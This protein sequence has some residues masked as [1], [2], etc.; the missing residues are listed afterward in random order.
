MANL[1]IIQSKIYEIRGQKVML[2]FDL[3]EL[4]SIETRVLKQAVRRNSARF[5]GEDFMFELTKEEISRSQIVILNK[6]RGSNIKYAPFAFTELGV[7]MLSS[8]LNS[9]TAI[10]IN[11]GIMRAFVAMRQL[12]HI[13]PVDNIG[14]LKNELK[15]LKEYIEDVFTDQNDIN[16]DTRMQL[17]LINQT[18]AEL[19]TKDRGFKERK[20]IGYKLPGC[21][22]EEKK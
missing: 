19:Q 13:S 11:R 15:E 4:Y 12:I 10:E 9:P 1:Q 20:R 14:E 5:E 3:A 17:E 6:G 16:E 2:D 8:V 7:A 18:L 22:E 21:E